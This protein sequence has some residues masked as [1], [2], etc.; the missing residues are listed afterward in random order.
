[1]IIAG[2]AAKDWGNAYNGANQ[3]F[4]GYLRPNLIAVV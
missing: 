1:M 2:G 4:Q 3:Y